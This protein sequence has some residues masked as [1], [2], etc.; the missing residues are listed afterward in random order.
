VNP[1]GERRWMV[2][3]PIDPGT[4]QD[5]VGWS[6]LAVLGPGGEP[7]SRSWAVA[8]RFHGAGAQAS[9]RGLLS[10]RSETTLQS[11]LT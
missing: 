5:F 11:T 2:A 1:A 3:V 10:A 6:G 9:M 4:E 7:R 8:N